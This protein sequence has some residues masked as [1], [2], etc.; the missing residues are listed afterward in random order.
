MRGLRA[1]PSI[2]FL[3]QS[4]LTATGSANIASAPRKLATTPHLNTTEATEFFNFFAT[5]TLPSRFSYDGY[6][7]SRWF[8]SAPGISAATIHAVIIGLILHPTLPHKANYQS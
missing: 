5:I 7:A 1:I 4:R 3:Y 2:Q 6:R 8:I